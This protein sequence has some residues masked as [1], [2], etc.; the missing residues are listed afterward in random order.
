MT[1]FLNVTQPYNW[2]MVQAFLYRRAI[3]GIETCEAMSYSR[4]FD[5]TE[6]YGQ[7][8]LKGL[9]TDSVTLS[10]SWFKA[11]YQPQ[12][13][14]FQ[15]ELRLHD[16]DCRQA[17]LAN[18]ARVLDAHQSMPMIEQALLDAG[19]TLADVT[20]GI[21]LP[22]T[23][24]PFEAL[25][26]A[27][28]GQQISVTGAV[29][30]LNKW[31]GSIRVATPNIKHFPVPRELAEALSHVDTPILPM[32][33]ARQQ[34]LLAASQYA[35]DQVLSS[36]DSINALLDIKGIGPWTVNY[37]LMRGLSAPDVFLHNDLVVKNQL[38]RFALVSPI[39]PALAAP[40]QSYVCIQ[41]WEHANT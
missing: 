25:I 4:Y 18:I 36:Q 27:I 1:E 17:V 20:P 38:A 16:P 34:T 2:T 31:I 33:K 6:F 39:R 41:L 30:L 11:T 23:W 3:A 24:S 40:W 15:I 7:Q 37:V 35:Q 26:R 22:A 8:S 19:F 13:Q 21:R 28:V 29:N 10:S 9:S 32:P 14:R 5:E 12:Q